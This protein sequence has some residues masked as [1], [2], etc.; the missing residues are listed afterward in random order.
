V[1]AIEIR[2]VSG[3]E[4]LERWV[5]LH[6]EIRPDNPATADWKALVRAVQTKRADLLAYLDGVAV[7]TAV[8]TANTHPEDPGRPYVHVG[9][10]PAYRGRGV[11]D[12]L[13][14]AISNHAGRFGHTGLACD[15][16]ADDEHSLA[17]LRRRGFVEHR[18]WEQFALDLD[19]HESPAHGPP[20]GVE[21]VSLPQRPELLERMHR[22]A[23]EVSPELGGPVG[24]LAEVFLTWQ[25]YAV[26]D[27]ILDLDLL[28]VAGGDVVGF[29]IAREYDDTTAELRMAA[30]L[31]DWRGR[32][33]G[34]ALIGAQVATAQ[35]T[36][37]GRVIAWVPA[38]TRPGEVY[39]RLG[40]AQTG[41]SIELHGPL[42]T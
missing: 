32:G 27:T 12:A 14:R 22:V 3:M 33:I 9:V 8:L 25:V 7:G 41:G 13:L 39:R 36:R 15:A 40:F 17:F 11:G 30:V 20:E 4:D 5:A 16:D 10:L 34:T 21:I 42:L 1:T 23:A 38:D 24:R 29:G 6:N 26:G 35:R 2:P 31:P 28:A 19:S 37:K 18:R